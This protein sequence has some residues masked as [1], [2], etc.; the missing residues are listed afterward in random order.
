MGSKA[1]EFGGWCRHSRYGLYRVEVFERIGTWYFEMA[2][3]TQI[4]QF[5]TAFFVRNKSNAQTR[6][7]LALSLI[8]PNSLDSHQVLS[9]QVKLV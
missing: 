6:T 2:E 3:K 5:G 7:P 9:M 1:Q 4:A 8:T